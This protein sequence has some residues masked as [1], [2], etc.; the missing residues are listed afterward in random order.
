MTD[1]M[2]ACPFCGKDMQRRDCDGEDYTVWCAN[3]GAIGPNAL[4]EKRADE[5][6]NI[7]PLEDAL[8]K[9]LASRDALI[10]QMIE[11]GDAVYRWNNY[12]DGQ[13]WDS[14]VAEYRATVS[15]TENVGGVE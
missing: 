13:A 7:R 4:T 2:K 3:C 9:Q 1:K 5:M 6:W 15:R 14:L 11:A 8:R 10:K 12:E